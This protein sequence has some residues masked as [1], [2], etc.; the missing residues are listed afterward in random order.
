MKLTLPATVVG[1]IALVAGTTAAI[2][3]PFEGVRYWAYR[4]VVGVPTVCAGHTGPDVKFGRKYTPEECSALLTSDMLV[5]VN[6]VA[7][8]VPNI[9]EPAHVAFADA[10]FN[11]GPTIACDKSRSTAASLLAQGR[12]AEACE[13]LPRW[14]KARVAGQ[15]VE[16]PGLTKRRNRLMNYCLDGLAA[17]G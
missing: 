9:P 11:M 10:V 16:L 13:Q 1:R 15:L 7:K 3:V 12:W 4:D 17:N 14:N 2:A 5:A 8:C 6:T